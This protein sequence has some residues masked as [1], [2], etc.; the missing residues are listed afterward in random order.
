MRPFPSWIARLGQL[1]PG[2]ATL[3]ENTQDADASSRATR[4]PCLLT[5]TTLSVVIRRRSSHP[6][7]AVPQHRRAA[8]GGHLLR[9]TNRQAACEGRSPP[10]CDALIVV[11]APNSSNSLVR[12]GWGAG[13]GCPSASRGNRPTFPGRLERIRDLGLTRG[14]GSGSPRDGNRRAF[15]AASM[16]RSK[17]SSHAGAHRVQRATWSCARLGCPSPRSIS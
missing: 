5:Q 9:T 10:R 1:P 13:A 16:S 2:A 7:T 17:M 8:Q 15:R 12:R 4:A 3:V 6:E 11:G 14:L